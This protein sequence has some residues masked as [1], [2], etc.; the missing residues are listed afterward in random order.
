MT[1]TG[2][3][4]DK[5]FNQSAW[6]GLQDAAAED[7]RLRIEFIETIALADYPNNIGSFIDRDADM[8]VTVGFGMGEATNIAASENLE[9]AF[10]GVDQ[11]QNELRE[12]VTGLV[13]NEDK[14]GFMAGALAGLMTK[15]NTVGAVLGTPMVPPVVAFKEGFENGARYVNPEVNLISTYH[16]GGLNTAF[17]DLA[18]GADTARQTMNHGADVIFG[19]GGTTGSGALIEVATEDG[20]L[21]IGVETDQW[22]TLPGAQPCLISSAMKLIDKGVKELVLKGVNGSLPA[23]NF[24]GEVGLASYHDLEDDV[25]SDIKDLVNTISAEVVSGAIDTGYSGG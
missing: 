16:P 5:S 23:G 7:D 12:N 18:W 22:E 4:D 14:A 3:V 17:D 20:A 24:F 15:S 13:F 8:I 1:D 25:P 19:A 6:E 2:K 9:I 10:I 21:C 11:F